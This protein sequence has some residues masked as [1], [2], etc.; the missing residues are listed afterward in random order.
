MTIAPAAPLG[1][2]IGSSAGGRDPAAIL[3]LFVSLLA[4]AVFAGLIPLGYWQADEYDNQVAFQAQGASFLFQRIR[5]WSYRPFSEALLFIYELAVRTTGRQLITS[6]LALLWMSLAASAVLPACLGGTGA[7]GGS[8]WGLVALSLTILAL[9]L[10]SGSIGEVFYWPQAAAAYMP[11]M[12]GL[13]LAVLLTAFCNAR[14]WTETLLLS[15]G[16]TIAALSAEVAAVFVAIYV[17]GNL[18]LLLVRRVRAAERPLLRTM[19][20]VQ[21]L[22]F[23]LS[24]AIVGLMVGGRLG[25]D[26][27]LFG[28]KMIAH[29]VWNSFAAALRRFPLEIVGLAE[30]DTAGRFGIAADLAAK[31]CLTAGSFLVF[32]RLEGARD[33]ERVIRLLILALAAL[34]S[35]FV[36]LFAAFYQF[37]VACCPRHQTVRECLAILVLVVLSRLLSMALGSSATP[38][39]SSRATRTGSARIGSALL[40]AAALIA[41]GA[42]ADRLLRNYAVFPEVVAARAA[43]WQAGR[44]SGRAMVF[45]QAALGP[46]TGG[47][48]WPP[49][50]YER[51]A[52]LHPYAR[53]IM[54]FFGKDELDIRPPPS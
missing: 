22:P 27:E 36:S 12:A 10:N 28:D 24:L 38:A 1:G 41:T 20:L 52:D 5:F 39:T 51:V 37:G 19:D 11:M 42:N 34:G 29:H 54:N 21:L 26:T 23:L 49:G 30:G 35:A 14:S 53:M 18:A 2:K 9:F 7:R 6:V 4:I 16:L 48:R 44:S 33:A 3:A 31:V 45:E 50:H 47:P 17:P 43:N 8:R 32:R 46:I 15:A 25:N 13:L 40:A